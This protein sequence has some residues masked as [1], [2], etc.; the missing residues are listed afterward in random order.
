LAEDLAKQG[1]TI[2]LKTANFEFSE[3]AVLHFLRSQDSIGIQVAD[4]LAGFIA[5][6]AQEAVWG[7]KPVHEDKVTIF[8]RLIAAGNR[9]TA[10]AST[11]WLPIV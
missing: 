11:S 3:A 2:P 5:R 7:G 10:R 1:A 9:S 6:Y 8:D 4:V